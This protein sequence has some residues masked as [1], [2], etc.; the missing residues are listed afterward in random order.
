MKPFHVFQ[1]PS[2][3]LKG[4]VYPKINIHS[5]S[6]D[7]FSSNCLSGVFS[8]S[9]ISTW[10]WTFLRHSGLIMWRKWRSF[11]FNLKKSIK[12]SPFNWCNQ[13]WVREWVKFSF[14]GWNKPLIPKSSHEC[15][16]MCS[17][18]GINI[19]HHHGHNTYEYNGMK[20]QEKNEVKIKNSWII[21]GLILV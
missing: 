14:F 7:S 6:A 10:T 12:W 11:F 1:P 16:V 18:K 8:N 19:T 9:L 20:I 3:P 15:P 2:C 4:T 5:L 13:R 21:F 17:S